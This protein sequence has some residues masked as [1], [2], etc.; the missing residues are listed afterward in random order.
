MAI[1][2]LH[3]R[4]SCRCDTIFIIGNEIMG[5]NT[6]KCQRMVSV[7]FKNKWLFDVEMNDN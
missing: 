6:Y 1:G 5:F 2:K 7:Y 3:V 4:L